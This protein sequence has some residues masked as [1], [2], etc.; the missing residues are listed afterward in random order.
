MLLGIH[1][2]VSTASQRA[3]G[4][5]SGIPPILRQAD[6]VLDSRQG[7]IFDGDDQVGRWGGQLH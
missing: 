2:G 3:P 4:D 5:D 6:L 7:V 1:N